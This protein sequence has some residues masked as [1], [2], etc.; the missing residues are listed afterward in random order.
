MRKDITKV[1]MEEPK[2]GSRDKFANYRH[3]KSF[4]IEDGPMRESMKARFNPFWG[5]KM[6]TYDFSPVIK[7]VK[8]QVNKPWDHI[9]STICG[10]FPNKHFMRQNLDYYLN[11]EFKR[12][13]MNSDGELY[14][15]IP[16]SC[17]L[18]HLISEGDAE[19]YIDLNGILR[20]NPNYQSFFKM[21]R[22]RNQTKLDKRFDTL[23]II[24]ENRVLRKIGD[25]WYHFELVD[26]GKPIQIRLSYREY[27]NRDDCST[28]LAYE[29]VKYFDSLKPIEQSQIYI[30]CLLHPNTMDE[31]VKHR[32]FFDTTTMSIRRKANRTV[33]NTFEVPLDWVDLYKK[34]HINKKTANKK[35]LKKMKII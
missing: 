14:I 8:T 27:K 20:R 30:D 11:R 9:Y 12:T 15:E 33:R 16:Y 1:V 35:L 25:V 4:N 24:D 23:R 3:R 29:R 6:Q 5:N 22:L 10:R 17:R 28:Y 19:Y 21:I 7:F 31:Y 32:L 34:V 18:Q 13:K 2:H 26:F